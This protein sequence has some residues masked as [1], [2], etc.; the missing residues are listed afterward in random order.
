MQRFLLTLVGILFATQSASAVVNIAVDVNDRSN[1]GLTQLGFESILISDGGVNAATKTFG[2]GVTLDI[3]AG[4]TAFRVN[5]DGSDR[6]R[7]QPTN[8]GSLTRSA[9]YRDFIFGDGTTNT[10]GLFSTFSGLTPGATYDITVTSFDDGSNSNR[11]SVWSAQG[12]STGYTFNGSTLPTSDTDDTLNLTAIA[13][14][15]GTLKV[16]GRANG[17]SPA[18]FL[19][20]IELVETDVTQ[21]VA[22]NT[23]FAVD[24]N[25]GGSPTEPGFDA[26]NLSAGTG[27]NSNVVLDG[28][29][30]TAFSSGGQQDL[31][32]PN[33]LTRDGIFD[34]G[35]NSAAGLR[36]NNLEDGIYQ[37][38]VFAFEDISTA[39]LG[40]LIVGITQTGSETIFTTNYTP[41]ANNPYTFIFNSAD[42]A[43]GFGI[44]TREGNDTDHTVFN[45]LR[46]TL[47]E[48]AT[49]PEPTTALLGLM[50]MAGLAAR[51]RRQAA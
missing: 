42:F 18:V 14:L 46:L 20:A 13:N 30:F 26:L 23:V 36:I 35:A 39:Q 25:S 22:S 44:F 41:D 5:A 31:G 10:S 29:T 49:I 21:L 17:A 37:A 9:I 6:V 3:D 7:A 16:E 48:D 24:I 43:N 12:N 28:V 40:N 15:D 8:G 19:N 45:G 38:E 32:S 2:N 51:R 11:S 1:P 33:D 34:N 50:G 27:D 47:L 4:S